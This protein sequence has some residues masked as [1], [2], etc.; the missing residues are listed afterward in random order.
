MPTQTTL[1]PSRTTLAPGRF[2]RLGAWAYRRR[3][4]ALVLWVA[5]LIGVSAAAQGIG[6]DWRNDFSLPGTESQKAADL[7]ANHAREQRGETVQVVV[8]ARDGVAAPPTRERVAE[9]LEAVGDLPGVAAVENPYRTRTISPDGTVALVNVALTET[10]GNV[11]VADTRRIIGAARAADGDGLQVEVGGDP[12]REAQEGEGQGGAE[13][14]GMLAALA[15]LVFM[16]G[17]LLAASLPLLIAVFAVGTAVGL[18][19]IASHVATIADFTTAV[20]ALVGLGVGI[21][22][23]LLVF[24]RYRSELL[25]G[26]DRERA[27]QIALDTAGRTVFFAGCT[28]IIALLGLVLLGLGSLQ[29][30]AVAVA[31]TVLA[32]MAAALTL[33]PALLA[34]FGPRL[35][36]S[37]RRRAGRKPHEGRRWRRWSALVQRRPW[38]FAIA[39]VVLLVALSLPATGTRLGFADASSDDP[40]TTSRQAYDLLADAFGPGFAGPLVVVSEGPASGDAALH[41]ALEDAGGVARVTPPARSADGKIATLIAFPATQPQSEATHD[42]V[43]RLRGDVL[44]GVERAT[45]ATVHVG[46]STAAAIDFSDAVA[47]KLPVFVG[48]VVGLSALLLMAVFRSLLIPIKAALFNLLSVG[49]SLGVMTLVFQDGVLG[50]ETG[51][52]EAFVPVMIFA[53]VFGLSMDYEVFLL[54]RMHEAWERTRDH[55]RAIGEGLA[56]TGRVVT[57]AAAIMVV[58][59]GAFVLSPSRMLQEFGLGLAVAILLD[60]VVVRCLLVP[61]VMQLLGRRA[62]WLPSPIAR[63]LPRV[64]LESAERTA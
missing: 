19:T 51:P 24:S 6:A 10:A 15:V 60:A 42:L 59:F 31:L 61:A 43:G 44:P 36:R 21:D 37:L 46:G 52:I 49:A 1:S 29:G 55:H 62:W 18:A 20:M 7:L 17:S 54:S 45:G 3:L 35:E 5:V 26:A 47:A 41:R 27:A 22:Y 57:A 9:M 40:S 56:T 11:D 50:G 23:A 32:T 33:L 39:G 38:P 63:R 8:R 64:A 48:A 30:V 14:A 28:V 58:V 25:G 53:I 13:G 2:V 16:F 34:Q 12:V 4:A